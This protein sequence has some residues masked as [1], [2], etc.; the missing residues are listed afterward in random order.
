MKGLLGVYLQ[1]F[2]TTLAVQVQYRAELSIWLIGQILEPLIALA[3]WSA[4]SRS[5]GGDVS[6]YTAAQFAAYFI[7]LMLVNHLTYTWIMF[8]FEYRV[9]HGSLSLALLRPLHPIHP[10]IAD[11]VS[12]K[13]ITFPLML[14]VA[15]TLALIFRP[16]FSLSAWAILAFIPS[17]LLAAA[18]RFIL[19]WTL[20]LAVF[21]TTRVSAVN[22]LYFVVTLFLSGQLAPLAV[23]PKVIQ[24]AAQIL[25]FRWMVGFP[26]ELLLGRLLPLQALEGLLIQ[27]AWLGLSLF[28]LR[29][30]WRAGTRMYSAVGA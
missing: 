2:R 16:V 8:E 21:W 30:V 5:S 29:A 22:Q 23:F 17:L 1:Q 9:R 25:P 27:A 11:N 28:I 7:V 20:S 6:G 12:Y 3:V 15:G 18:L 24:V 10:D 19:E 4:V 13:L 26:V 14:V